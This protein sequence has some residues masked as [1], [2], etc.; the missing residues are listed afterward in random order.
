MKNVLAFNLKRNKLKLDLGLEVDMIEEEIQEF[1]NAKNLAEQIDAMADV[2]YVYEGT[3]LKHSYNMQV[4]DEDITKIVGQFHRLSVNIVSQ[5]LGDNSQYLDKIMN[6]AWDVVCEINAE[7][8]TAKDD[9]GKVTKHKSLRNATNEIRE[10]LD[11][12]T[13]VVVEENDGEEG[14]H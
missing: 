12:M 3:Q 4:M 5:E 7:K 2:R 8:G 9:N 10:F 1:Y 14:T 11:A 13:G 6:H